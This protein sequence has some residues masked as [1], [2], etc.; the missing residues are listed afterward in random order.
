MALHFSQYQSESEVETD[1][2][3]KRIKTEPLQ[4]KAQQYAKAKVEQDKARIL[5][6]PAAAL[7]SQLL[8][9]AW[10]YQRDEKCYLQ[11]IC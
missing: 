9:V 5:Q 11:C 8:Q 3:C 1:H 4:S 6:P 7:S 10:C 2:I